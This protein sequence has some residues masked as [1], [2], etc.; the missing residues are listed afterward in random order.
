MQNKFCRICWNTSGWRIPTGDRTETGNSYVA[1][2]GFGHE[3]WLFNYE[4]LIDGYRYGFLQPIGKYLSKYTGHHCSITLYTLTSDKNILLIGRMDNVYIPDSDELQQV[5][6][7]Y[8]ERG[9]LDQMRDHVTDIDGD[10][11]E[12]QNPQPRTIANLRFLPEDVHIFDPRPRVIGNHTIL[13]NLR[14]QPFNWIS[15][16]PTTEFQPPP[17]HLDDPR[18]SEHE[19]ARA[20]QEASTVDP[21]HTRLQNLLYEHLCALNGP[22]N[23][24]Y[25][26]NYVDLIVS[27]PDRDVYF[28]IKIEPSAKRCIRPGLVFCPPAE[29][30]EPMS[31]LAIPF[32]MWQCAGHGDAAGPGFVR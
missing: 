19:R 14:Y 1:E 8:T 20:A 22:D 32:S 11:G 25:E 12:L 30:R 13:T 3:E 15:D 17:H 26:H 18:R 5:S 31:G 9:W 2:H 7:I 4:W 29:H 6:D 21:K 23:V 10:I 27:D 24:R 16:Y 28:E